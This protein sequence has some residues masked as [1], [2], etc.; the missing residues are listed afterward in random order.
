MIINNSPSSLHNWKKNSKKK[1]LKSINWVLSLNSSK[2]WKI[3]LNHWW[4]N[5]KSR[6]ITVKELKVNSNKFVQTKRKLRKI[7]RIRNLLYL[8]FKKERSF[9]WEINSCLNPEFNRLIDIF[10]VRW[11]IIMNHFQQLGSNGLS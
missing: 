9:L 5:L 7:L 6:E 4:R 11:K 8:K 2:T 1:W 10:L 3:K